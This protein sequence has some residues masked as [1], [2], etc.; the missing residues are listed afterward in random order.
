[1]NKKQDEENNE[2]KAK[3]KDLLELN[4]KIEFCWQFYS[5][6]LPCFEKKRIFD[7]KEMDSFISCIFKSGERLWRHLL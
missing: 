2:N 1:M 7:Q 4:H 5:P 6:F 3:K